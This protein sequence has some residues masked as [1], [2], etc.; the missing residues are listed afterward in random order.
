MVCRNK[1]W[2]YCVGIWREGIVDGWCKLVSIE[3]DGIRSGSIY[4][5]VYLVLLV[6]L[7]VFW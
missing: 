2:C 5:M 7:V 1:W 6:E 3:S 4:C